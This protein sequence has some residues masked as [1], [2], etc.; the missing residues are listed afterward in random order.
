MISQTIPTVTERFEQESVMQPDPAPTGTNRYHVHVYTTIRIKVA[1]QAHD[2]NSAMTAADRLLFE[3]GIAVALVPSG[4]HVEAAEH[5]DE[6]LGYLVD[7]AG[8]ED[9]QR[10]RSY[11]PG[12]QPEGPTNGE[13]GR[14]ADPG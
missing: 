12:H 4:A 13:I 1:V 8:D 7:E 5:A 14:R 9:Y 6:V 3:D 10:T 2:H 11:G